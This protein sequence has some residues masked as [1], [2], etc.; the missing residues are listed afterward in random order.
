MALHYRRAEAEVTDLI[1][2]DSE[3]G[4]DE[5]LVKTPVLKTTTSASSIQSPEEAP[6]TFTDPGSS[7][8][9]A[10]Q[11]PGPIQVEEG[12]PVEG[13]ASA[14]PQRQAQPRPLTESRSRSQ[15]SMKSLLANMSIS[16]PP[17]VPRRRADTGESSGS[18]SESSPYPETTSAPSP[19]IALKNPSRR[20][21]HASDDYIQDRHRGSMSEGGSDEEVEEVQPFDLERDIGADVP[22]PRATEP[23]SLPRQHIP[24]KPGLLMSQKSAPSNTSP[25][26]SPPSSPRQGEGMTHAKTMDYQ[27]GE[28]PL[29]KL[30]RVK[31]FIMV[32]GSFVSFIHFSFISRSFFISFYLSSISPRSLFCAYPSTY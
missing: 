16:S 23:P 15:P 28:E 11:R 7:E 3:S 29:R 4:S 12:S 27:P 10:G 1:L 2:D 19:G 22:G 5:E 21:L 18:Y 31:D 9:M 25:A 17:P 20:R 32:C 13:P 6:V 30:T 26:A 8:L 24:R 14:V